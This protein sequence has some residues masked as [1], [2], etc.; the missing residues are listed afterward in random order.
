MRI[1]HKIFF[2]FFSSLVFIKILFIF[3]IKKWIIHKWCRC[4]KN[5]IKLIHKWIVKSLSTESWPYSKE[6]LNNNIQNIFMYTIQNQNWIPSISFSSMNKH[7]RLQKHKLSNCIV[8]TSS[9][10]LSFFSKNT[11]ANMSRLNHRDIIS[12]I[13]N[14]ESHFIREPKPDHIDNIGFLLR[15]YPT[16][17]YDVDMI[18]NFHK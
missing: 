12:S 13:S 8:S 3:E 18:T 15:W 14:A 4:I 9:S 6:V 5:I 2:T 11:N 7:K 10:L 1:S 17:K 16:C